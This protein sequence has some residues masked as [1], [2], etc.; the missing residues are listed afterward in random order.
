MMERHHFIT[1]KRI[2]KSVLYFLFV[3]ASGSEFVFWN[4]ELFKLFFVFLK[5]SLSKN[6]CYVSCYNRAIVTVFSSIYLK[7]KCLHLGI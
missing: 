5:F 1:N 2:L 3:R 7:N 4:T 6:I